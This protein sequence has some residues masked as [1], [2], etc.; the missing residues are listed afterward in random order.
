MTNNEIIFRT[1]EALAAAGKIKRD[2]ETGLPEELHT[3]AAWK[4]AG[5]TVKRGEHATA[6]IDIWK[7]GK[8]REKTNENGET[9]TIP[10]K[11]FMKTAYFFTRS[12]VE[13]ITT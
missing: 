12:Q 3:F 13:P 4:A 6:V 7:Q 9:I 8:A 5:Y 11:M 1:A 10:A 2:T